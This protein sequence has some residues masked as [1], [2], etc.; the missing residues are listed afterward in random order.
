[1]QAVLRGGL[2]PGYR[3]GYPVLTTFPRKKKNDDNYRIMWIV[4]PI[5]SLLHFLAMLSECCPQSIWS[6]NFFLRSFAVDKFHIG[7][8]D[9]EVIG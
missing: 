7:T 4:Y 6:Q 1:M 3:H 8:L 2:N 5:P 9:A